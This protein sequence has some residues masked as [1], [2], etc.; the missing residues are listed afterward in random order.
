MTFV[1][2]I[3]LAVVMV[4]IYQIA[5]PYRYLPS[6]TEEELERWAYYDYLIENSSSEDSGMD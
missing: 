3:W 5:V 1:M 4:G 2:F 6:Y